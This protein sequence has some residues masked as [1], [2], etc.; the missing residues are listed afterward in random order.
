MDGQF[1][2]IYE[3]NGGHSPAVVGWDRARSSIVW[4]D[5][6]R[7]LSDRFLYL[8]AHAFETDFMA[9]HG[10]LGFGVPSEAQVTIDDVES[11]LT[12]GHFSRGVGVGDTGVLISYVSII[13]PAAKNGI[14]TTCCNRN[15][16][17]QRYHHR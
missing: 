2:S 9:Q 16:Y 12:N 6:S 4:L 3:M 14:T 8:L 7:V 5:G 10:I 17:H 13:A 15:H 1:G 11:T